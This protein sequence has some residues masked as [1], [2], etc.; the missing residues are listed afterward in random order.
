MH[1]WVVT[2]IV[3]LVAYCGVMSDRSEPSPVEN[4]G[5]SDVLSFSD[6][7][8]AVS[9]QNHSAT[10]GFARPDPFAAVTDARTD[11]RD[12]PALGA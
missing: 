4:P 11:F 12:R 9:T 8:P 6:I 1:C 5:A 3:A 10:G 7:E 2:G